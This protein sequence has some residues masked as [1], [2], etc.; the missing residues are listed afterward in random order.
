MHEIKIHRGENGNFKGMK[1][2]DTFKKMNIEFFKDENMKEVDES[3]R[4]KHEMLTERL[5]SCFNT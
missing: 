5:Q 2:N 3:K 4:L 1:L